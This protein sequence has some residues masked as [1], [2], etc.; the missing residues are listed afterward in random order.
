[1]LVAV[2]VATLYARDQLSLLGC[3]SYLPSNKH[4]LAHDVSCKIKLIPTAP[5]CGTTEE[6]DGYLI[7]TFFF[8]ARKTI[9]YLAV[10]RNLVVN[11]VRTGQ[12][13][14]TQDSNRCQPSIILHAV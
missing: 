10:I 1:M 2:D 11:W 7:D 6:R 14:E 3:Y 9:G 13:G 4:T 12:G 8:L 5:T